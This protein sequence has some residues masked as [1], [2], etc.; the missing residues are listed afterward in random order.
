MNFSLSSREDLSL[1]M[2]E[3]QPTNPFSEMIGMHEQPSDLSC[4]ECTDAQDILVVDA[5]PPNASIDLILDDLD[6][7][8][9]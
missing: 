9:D 6:R 3:E 5:D 7:S 8:L 2:G 1:H 4:G